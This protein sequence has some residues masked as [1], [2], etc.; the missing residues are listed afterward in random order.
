MPAN[1]TPAS[2][3]AIPIMGRIKGAG[4]APPKSRN[5]KSSRTCLLLGNVWLLRPTTWRRRRRIGIFKPIMYVSLGLRRCV[6]VFVGGGRYHWQ[7]NHP[8]T[9]ERK[10]DWTV[11]QISTP[12]PLSSPVPQKWLFSRRNIWEKAGGCTG[13]Y[14]WMGEQQ[15][16]A[17]GSGDW[18]KKRI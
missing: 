10:T 5:N 11:V 15:K 18:K 16:S 9:D 13:A 4:T 3:A 12:L 7:A 14:P 2:C 17:W 8:Q 6:F 1:G